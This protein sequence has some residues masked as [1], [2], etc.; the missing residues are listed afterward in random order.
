MATMINRR[1]IVYLWIGEPLDF[2]Q[3]YANYKMTK[4]H[5]IRLV[6]LALFEENN[7]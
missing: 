3:W 4:T 5:R 7:R 6:V 2:D 1:E